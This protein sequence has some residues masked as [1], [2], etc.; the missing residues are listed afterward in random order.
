[1]S[2]ELGSMMTA[3]SSPV[4]I[5]RDNLAATTEAAAVESFRKGAAT[6]LREHDLQIL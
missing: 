4:G 3:I 6:G 2:A 5:A 1:V